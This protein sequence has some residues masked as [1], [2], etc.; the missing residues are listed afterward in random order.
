MNK[1]K[2]TKGLTFLETIITLVIISGVSFFLF[3]KISKDNEKKD[4]EKSRRIFQE[5]FFRY[6]RKSF[7]ENK[8]FKIDI[9]L[10]DKKVVIKTFSKDVLEE[11]KLPQKIKYEIIYGNMRHRIFNIETTKNGNLNK[12]FTLYNFGYKGDVQNRIAF[13]VFQKEKIL[14]I[15]TYLNNNIKNINYENI[16]NYHYSADGQNRIGWIEED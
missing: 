2:K 10:V 12:A 4:L 11:I 7:Y 9:H 15:N 3:I 16:L 13:Y 1:I 6:S 5:L 14:K 8:I